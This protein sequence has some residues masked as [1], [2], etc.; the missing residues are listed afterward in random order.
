MINSLYLSNQLGDIGRNID[1][2]QRNFDKAM[3][4][5]YTGR[6][7]LVSRTEKLRELGVAASKSL[8]ASIADKV[9]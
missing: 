6:G 9:E 5:L 2:A 3:G 8:P 4:Q 7:N 1:A